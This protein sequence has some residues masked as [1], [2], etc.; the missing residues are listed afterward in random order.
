LNQCENVNIG[1]KF[2]TC[3]D[4]ILKMDMLILNIIWYTH[5]SKHNIV[6]HSYNKYNIDIIMS[7]RTD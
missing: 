2:T 3:S 1:Y 5:K 4:V 6:L 7:R